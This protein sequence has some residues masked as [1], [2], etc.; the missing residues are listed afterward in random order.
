MQLNH[1]IGTPRVFAFILFII[2]CIA[3][4]TF[5]NVTTVN[6]FHEAQKRAASEPERIMLVTDTG[7]QVIDAADYRTAN[8]Q[9]RAD[10]LQDYTYRN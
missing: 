6:G 8:A 1:T 3:Y 10:H 2:I 9:W 5:A 7:T 4:V